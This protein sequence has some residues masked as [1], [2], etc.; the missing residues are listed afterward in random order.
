MSFT[1]FFSFAVSS[2]VAIWKNCHY[3]CFDVH[4]F[5]PYAND[6]L[7]IASF[8]WRLDKRTLAW[9]VA[10]AVNPWN[11]E[12]SL[13][14]VS[15]FLIL[16]TTVQLVMLP[17][18]LKENTPTVKCTT[19]TTR[20]WYQGDPMRSKAYHCVPPLHPVSHNFLRTYQNHYQSY[21][22]TGSRFLVSSGVQL[23]GHVMETLW[24]PW[25]NTV[26]Q[27]PHRV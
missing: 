26:P 14:L 8:V 16:Q 12:L 10:S 24:C 13:V 17:Y 2:K 4:L 18:R 6:M 20:A 11:L 27:Y 5:L 15:S 21:R 19:I 22:I 7:L 3:Q 9:T 23:N 25:K 1:N